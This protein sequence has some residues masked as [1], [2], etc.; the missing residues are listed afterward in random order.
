MTGGR[1]V[2][3]Y[4]RARCH[5]CD[6]ARAII[7]AERGRADFPFREVLID[8]DDGLEREYGFRVP[9]VTV[10]GREEFEFAV[11]PARLRALL[12]A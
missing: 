6:E 11:D 5:L 2:V 10:G 8:G 4:S 9:V 1:T 12:R 7:V 3:L